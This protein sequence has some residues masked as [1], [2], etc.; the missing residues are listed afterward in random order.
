MRTFILLLAALCALVFFAFQG[1]E[2]ALAAPSGNE[3][4]RRAPGDPPKS[5]KATKT[6]A[7]KKTPA[8][9]VRHG[10]LTGASRGSGRGGTR[11]SP[12]QRGFPLSGADSP[13]MST[14]KQKH[15]GVWSPEQVC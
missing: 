8:A 3:L 10:E 1:A 13:S 15:Q 7:P 14:D 9:K 2:K 6:A 11:D 5:P 12:L 4:P